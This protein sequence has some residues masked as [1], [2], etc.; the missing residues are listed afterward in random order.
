VKGEVLGTVQAINP[1]E[2]TFTENDLRLLV[3][4]ANL[5]SSAIANAQQFARTQAAEARYLGLFEDSI[6]PIILTDKT[7]NIVE[8]NKPACVFLEYERDELLKLSLGDLH[9]DIRDTINQR[10]LDGLG[11]S[12]ISIFSSTVQTKN[13]IGI[14][15][16]VHGKR[17]TTDDNELLQW[18]HHDISKQVEL[19][20]MRE[21]LMAMLF[22]DLQNPLGN[23]LASMELLNFEL[24]AD[25][26]PILLSIVDIA[27]RSSKRLQT[28]VHS[29]LDINRLEAGHPISDQEMVDIRNL[30]NEAEE[31]IRPNLERR[32]INLKVNFPPVLPQFYLDE[33]M[34]RRVIINLLD[35]ALKF[36]PDNQTIVLDISF[37][38]EV[39]EA[40][41]SISDRGVG[42]PEQYW[43]T[44]FD[45][46][47]RIQAT[48]GPKGLGLGL[49]F[50]RLAV[51]AHGGRIWIDRADSGGAK[52]NFTLPTPSDS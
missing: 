41:I 10:F 42:I 51:E 6:D 50:C 4:L 31:M 28:L 20:E 29:L 26:D 17:V 24:P 13:Q 25:A 38:P 39:D 14:L 43:E 22:H 21:D 34:I 23:I 19:D 27:T 47:R 44:V 37:K 7:G 33:D 15:V 16:E 18:I 9:P 1:I 35:N 36:S 32:G 30:I 12:E 52:F 40:L 46:F 2:G 8:V 49:A 45:K 5:A 48:G 11:T 3:N